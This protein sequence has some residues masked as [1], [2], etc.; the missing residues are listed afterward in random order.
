MQGRGARV[1]G[2]TR[3]EDCE[4]AAVVAVRRRDETGAGVQVVMVQRSTNRPTTR[5]VSTDAKPESNI[6]DTG[7][8]SALASASAFNIVSDQHRAGAHGG[9]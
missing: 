4:V 3:R 5:A 9:A 8:A 7:G 1:H 2:A 6:P